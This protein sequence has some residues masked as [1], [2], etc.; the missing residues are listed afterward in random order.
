MAGE[1]EVLV[2][3]N[4]KRRLYIRGVRDPEGRLLGYYERYERFAPGGP[5]AAPPEGVRGDSL[6]RF[7]G[8]PM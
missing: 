7:A 4:E 2:S 5:S 1:E 3:E 8:R 6:G